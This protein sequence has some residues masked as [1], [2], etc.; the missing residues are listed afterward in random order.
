MLRQDFLSA[1]AAVPFVVHGGA[2][3][4]SSQGNASS[5]LGGA[6]VL[7]GGGARGAYEA[8]AITALVETHGIKDGEKLP[9]IDVVCGASIGAINGWLVA[10]AQYFAYGRAL[11]GHRFR[12]AFC[13]ETSVR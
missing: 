11:A 3:Q 5:R 9:G 12:S 8:G 2:P 4:G 13:T 10:A 6:L 7:S 1:L